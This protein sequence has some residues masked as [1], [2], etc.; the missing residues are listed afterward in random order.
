MIVTS[1][2]DSLIVPFPSNNKPLYSFEKLIGAA[3]QFVYSQDSLST[4]NCGDEPFGHSVTSFPPQISQMQSFLLEMMEWNKRHS[5][6]QRF[7]LRTWLS[8]S[9]HIIFS[10]N[11][12]KLLNRRF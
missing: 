11:I 6:Q 2:L 3:V 10:K 1:R 5:I 12:Q 8:I 7:L 9:M 4:S